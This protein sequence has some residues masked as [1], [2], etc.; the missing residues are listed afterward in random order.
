MQVQGAPASS[1]SRDVC[2]WTGSGFTSLPNKNP[3]T[4]YVLR[5]SK[6]V[7]LRFFLVQHGAL[8]TLTHDLA[9]IN[10]TYWD[11]WLN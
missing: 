8:A 9:V 3:S 6:S 11:Q 4:G 5:S 10:I 7:T 2:A 1:L